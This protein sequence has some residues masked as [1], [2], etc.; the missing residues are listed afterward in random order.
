MGTDI[1]T[2]V[3]LNTDD[4]DAIIAS[5]KEQIETME[6]ERSGLFL[7][8]P[9]RNPNLADSFASIPRVAFKLDKGMEID[10]DEDMP[11]HKIIEGDNLKIMASLEICFGGKVDLIV[12]DPPYNTGKDFRYNDNYKGGKASILDTDDKN[13]HAHWLTFMRERLFAMRKMLSNS[14]IIAI[15]IDSREE[16]HLGC[17]MNEIFGEDNFITKLTWVKKA[18]ANDAKR[19]QELTEA[20]FIYAKDIN[21]AV[22]KRM[23]RDPEKDMKAYDKNKLDDDVEPWTG[24]QLTAR[25]GTQDFCY[26]VTLHR[27]TALPWHTLLDTGTTDHCRHPKRIW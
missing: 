23:K 8:Y 20:V 17:L 21:K 15:C 4:K 12:T 16:T 11:A 2:L 24:Y 10:N 26:P 9:G 27:R 7:S 25:S 14:G 22:I 13:R 6:R 18:A 3:D 1:N 5:L 19:F